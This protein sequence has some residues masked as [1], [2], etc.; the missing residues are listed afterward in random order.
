M[1]IDDTNTLRHPSGGPAPFRPA[2]IVAFFARRDRS[3]LIVMLI[4]LMAVGYGA[5][6]T[7]QLLAAGLV[8]GGIYAVGA[9]ALSLSYGVLGFP[10]IAQGLTMMLSAY[11]AFFFY[12]GR[13][14]KS[15]LVS[16]DAVLGLN[17]G[18]LPYGATA[19]G[20]LSFGYGLLLASVAAAAVTA[21]VLLLID[22]FVYAPPRKAKRDTPLG[23]TILSFGVTYVLLGTIAMIWGTLPRNI[24]TGIQPAIEFLPG[25]FLKP[26]QLFILAGVALTIAATYMF[27][28]YTRSGKAIRAVMDNAALAQASGISTRWMVRLTWLLVAVL[29]AIGGLFLGL[30]AQLNPQLGMVLIL[31]LFA[32]AALGGIGNP[33]GAAA[34]GLAI[35][36]LQELAVGFVSPG[37]KMSVAFVVLMGVLLIRPTGFGRSKRREA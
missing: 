27:L 33:L 5:L 28:A 23:L 29:T 30:Q 4:F 25:V 26:D 12:T 37:Y 10:N 2:G 1:A 11:F 16:G 36:I 7:P 14:R 9:M 35:G 34:G 17:F 20:K 13:V 19:L 15:A 6:V 8:I 24:T 3:K 31:P 18:N 21:L 22:R 32:A